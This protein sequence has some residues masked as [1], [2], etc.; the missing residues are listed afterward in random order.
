MLWDQHR[1]QVLSFVVVAASSIT[2]PVCNMQLPR[3]RL[4]TCCTT[5]G[6]PPVFFEGPTPGVSLL[7]AKSLPLDILSST[8]SVVG[9]DQLQDAQHPAQLEV[10]YSSMNQPQR[11]LVLG[12]QQQRLNC[13]MSMQGLGTA[14][15]QVSFAGETA[16]QQPRYVLYPLHLTNAKHSI[17]RPIW[18]LVCPDSAVAS[19]IQRCVLLCIR[20]DHKRH[21]PF[22]QAGSIAISLLLLTA[23]AGC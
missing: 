2:Q 17:S 18:L 8:C 10:A 19:S 1:M 12:S 23:H 13:S 7:G 6:R 15:L 16:D 21:A 3:M 4:Q 14:M 11:A 5:V 22:D 9:W 20:G